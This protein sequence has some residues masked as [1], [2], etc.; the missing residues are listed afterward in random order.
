MDR[1]S[2]LT[3]RFG[4]GLIPHLSGQ[5]YTIIRG[6]NHFFFPLYIIELFGVGIK[7]TQSVIIDHNA[8]R[9]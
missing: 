6:S 7:Q 2:A 9:L 1:P 5:M 3:P 8:T 4:P